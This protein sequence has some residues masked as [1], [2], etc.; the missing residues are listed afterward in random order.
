LAP[1]EGYAYLLSTG[2]IAYCK[3]PET[4]NERVPG[5][6][7]VWRARVIKPRRLQKYGA[8]IPR[9]ES[10]R[11]V[12]TNKR[13]RELPRSGIRIL[14]GEILPTVLRREPFNCG[15]DVMVTEPRSC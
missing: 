6:L 5:V 11:F 13:G 9:F 1:D 4:A 8:V 14:E 7:G 15:Q 10:V 2:Y 12:N 3:N